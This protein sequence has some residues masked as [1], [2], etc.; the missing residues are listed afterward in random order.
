MTK[1]IVIGQINGQMDC[2]IARPGYS[3]DV[4]DVNDR[5][6]ISFAASRSANAALAEA[7]F[8]TVGNTN[9]PLTQSYSTIPFLVNTQ[10]IDQFT[11]T[12]LQRRYSNASN[13]FDT[14]VGVSVVTTTNLLI[15]AAGYGNIA[16]VVTRPPNESYNYFTVK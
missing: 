13:T 4:D 11:Y 1:R 6:K 16:G 14:T 12:G 15:T 9:Y 7:G 5:K 3:A 10:T 2:R 8:I